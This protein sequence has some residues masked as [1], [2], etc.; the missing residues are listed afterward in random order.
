MDKG[1]L[2][3]LQG[4]PASGKTTKAK[5]LFK[6]GKNIRLNRDLLREMMHF[7]KYSKL[8]EREI[9][10]VEKV[11]A[12]Y[13]LSWDFDVIVD[14]T[15]LKPK[16]IQMWKDVA[17]WKNCEIEFIKI[18]TSLKECIKRDS[19]REKSVGAEV[20]KKMVEWDETVDSH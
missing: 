3:I 8:T 12:Q 6:E 1:K 18:D 5:K 16:T 15:N 19:K 9:M 10:N 7:G 17:S 4:L 13:F 11:I 2:I 14:D 20:I